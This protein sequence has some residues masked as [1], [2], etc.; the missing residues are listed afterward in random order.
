MGSA[1][2]LEILV[3]M[4][5]I[6]EH[7][8]TAPAFEPT[9]DGTSWRYKAGFEG[10]VL[11]PTHARVGPLGSRLSANEETVGDPRVAVFGDSITFG[12]AVPSSMTFCA[13]LE[14][15]LRRRWPAL[16]VLNF[17]VQGHSLDMEVGHVA[18]LLPEVEPRVVV[19]AFGSDDLNPERAQNYVDRYGY[20]TK[21]AFGPSSPVAD[22]VRATMRE[23]RLA[24]AMKNAYLQW[25]IRRAQGRAPADHGAPDLE[26]TLGVFRASM[27]R[28]DS[29]TRGRRRIVVC[30]DLRE[31]PLARALGDVMRSDFP[32]IEYVSAPPIPDEKVLESLRV[33]RDGHPNARAHSLYAHLLDGP[34]RRALAA[35]SPAIGP[36]PGERHEAV[37]SALP[38]SRGA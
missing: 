32:D 4:S 34:V 14:R 23:S 12:Q 19:L 37:R 31:S 25:Q 5:G 24:L 22:A 18:D 1:V 36:S 7:L 30:L 11:G 16:R 15:H 33:P 13:K 20:L 35:P 17:G 26:G 2:L 6:A 29:L 38:G 28:F 21:K 9:R 10:T 3:R 27:R 8:Y